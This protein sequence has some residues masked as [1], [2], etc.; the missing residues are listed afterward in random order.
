MLILKAQKGCVFLPLIKSLGEDQLLARTQ[1]GCVFCAFNQRE[2]RA[3]KR[4]FF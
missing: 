1:K 2:H 4:L 3:K